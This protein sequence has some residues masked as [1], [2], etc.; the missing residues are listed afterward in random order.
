M[1]KNHQFGK[2][3]GNTKAKLSAWK[4]TKILQMLAD[5]EKQTYIAALMKVSEATISRI[6]KRITWPHISTPFDLARKSDATKTP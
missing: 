4:V 6:S 2:G 1:K 5:G 3:T